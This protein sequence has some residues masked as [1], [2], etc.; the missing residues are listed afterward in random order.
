MP[1]EEEKFAEAN[2]EPEVSPKRV[3]LLYGDIGSRKTTT[4]ASLVNKQGLLLSTD[5][6]W[7]SLLNPRHKEIYDKL[8]ITPL[9]ALSQFDYIN[10]EGYDTVIWDTASHT[11]DSFLDLLYDK[12][13]WAGKFRDKITTNDPELKRLKIQALAP[14][15]YRVTRDT[16]RP[17]FRKLFSEI[18]AHIVITSQFKKPVP[19]LSKDEQI[20]PDIPGATL[21]IIGEKTDL[22]AHTKALNGKYVVDFSN[23]LT[24]LGK[25]RIEGIDGSMDSETFIRKYK[26]IVFK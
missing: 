20:R 15:D 23:N 16:L 2:R 7:T 6:S 21:K 9:T 24:Q 17:M 11:V 10:F 3:T 19:G 5:D 13:D 18:T 25:S 26:E 12:A 1:T 8:K 22:I 14:M 4:A